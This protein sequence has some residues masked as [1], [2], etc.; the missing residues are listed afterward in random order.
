MVVSL[1]SLRD[2]LGHAVLL[3]A[4]SAAAATAA[5]GTYKAQRFDVTAKAANGGLEVTESITFEFQSGTFTKVWRE[6]PSARTDG[7]EILDARMDGTLAPAGD[8]PGHVQISGRG[9]VR[10][11]WQFAELGPSVHRFDL[12]YLARGVVYRD[13]DY[14]V[15]RWRALPAEHKYTI[16]A[17]RIAFEPAG[18]RV[19]PLDTR[20]LR[21]AIEHTSNEGTTIEA[22]EIQSNGWIVAELRYPAGTLAAVQPDWF[23]R[24]AQAGALAPTWATIAAAVFGAALLLVIA[25][26]RGHSAPDGIP[27][28]TA[29][30]EPPRRL[31]AALV[32]VLA[33]KGRASGYQGIAAILDLADRGI[34]AVREVPGVFGIRSYELSQVP[35]THDLAPHEEVAL[36]VA[37]GGGGD[38]VS[39][40]RARRRLTRGAGRISAAINADLGSRGFVD[41]GRKA[42]RDRLTLLSGGLLIAAAIG[43]VAAAPLIQ[44]Y[45]GW[46]FLIPLALGVAGIVGIVMAASATPLS[47]EGLVEAARWRGFK[48]YLKA[49]ASGDGRGGPV[50]SR[51]IVYAIALGLGE[52]FAR[53]LRRQPGLAPP[54]FISSSVD[55]S[56]A[57]AAFVGSHAASASGTGGGGAGAAA[58]GGSSGAG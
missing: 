32:S 48:R 33:T 39:L 43:S 8:G 22:R 18:A 50:P 15:V 36:T 5:P 10:V 26:R 58:G 24:E 7:I 19:K 13:G 6:I 23:T 1:R 55:D 12:H 17:S 16:D 31:P 51:W 27:V 38:D 40:A 56:A 46:P 47:D 42:A 44:R 14:D 37:F 28:E 11:Q 53:Y 25:L 29:A 4:C 34:L 45:Q 21:S 9:R 35:G 52:R 57:F 41:P 3:L 30:S 2:R 49:L 20:R 54:W